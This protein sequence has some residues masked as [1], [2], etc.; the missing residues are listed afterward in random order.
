MTEP[1]RHRD[2]WNTLL[3]AVL[4]L[5]GI[6]VLSL[7]V[8]EAAVVGEFTVLGL[9]I[10]AVMLPACASGMVQRLGDGA[11][12]EASD[13]TALLRTIAERL[14]MSDLERRMADRVR[15]R[16]SLRRSIQHDLDQ[17]DYEAALRLVDEM[18]DQ[19]G[20]VEEA[21]HFRQQIIDARQRQRDREVERA[22]IEVDEICNRFDWPAARREVERLQRLY[23]GDPR[24]EALPQRVERARD[25][26]KHDVERRFLRA[27][28]V[29]DTDQAMQ[30]L[31]ELDMYLTPQ[32]AEA[33]L[34]T[35]R[36][37]VG[38]ARENT[39]VRFRM[40]VSDRDWVEAVKVG[41][42]IVREFPNS[43]MAEEVRGMMDLLRERAAGQHAADSGAATETAAEAGAASTGS[44]RAGQ[45]TPSA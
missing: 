25:E 14:S 33:Y 2:L 17:G 28:E 40:A 39:A 34:E 43:Q 19:F 41:E 22:V 38:Q 29:G 37:V 9:G 36:G 12:E 4:L 10:I 5:M 24:I 16:N 21:E 13:Q 11:R 45:P 7:G 42:Q 1:N 15:D 18:A 32:E 20:Y 35:A 26:H 23:A 3:F 27:A 6:A 30:L 31:K 8:Y 44:S